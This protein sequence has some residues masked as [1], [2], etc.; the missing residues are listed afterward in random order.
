MPWTFAHPAAVLPLQRIG[1]W[2]L[3]FSALVVGS[4]APDFGY[5]AGQYPLAAFAHSPQGIVALCLPLGLLVLALWLRLRRPLAALLPQPHRSALLALCGAPAPPWRAA[6]PASALA[7]VLGACTHAGWDACTHEYG[8]V[9]QRLAWLQAPLL[10]AAGREVHVYNLLQHASTLVGLG[11]LVQ[12]YR[13]WLRRQPV[14]PTSDAGAERAR[15]LFLGLALLAALGI[16][17]AAVWAWVAPAAHPASWLLVRTVVATTTV[18]G[19]L[20]LGGAGVLARRSA[21]SAG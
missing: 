17:V 8:W 21:R 1:P 4:L 13:R 3:P 7:I 10:Q 6:L 11:L 14:P 18:Y 9:V 5:Y 19:L 2:R 12:A 20:L 16:A 15:W